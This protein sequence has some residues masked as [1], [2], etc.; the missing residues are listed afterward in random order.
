MSHLFSLVSP[1]TYLYVNFYLPVVNIQFLS[2][3]NEFKYY[4]IDKI[5]Q[6]IVQRGGFEGVLSSLKLILSLNIKY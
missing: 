6:A 1:E 2:R 3:T 5:L 4:Y